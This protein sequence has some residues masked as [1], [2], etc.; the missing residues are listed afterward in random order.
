MLYHRLC[1]HYV[2]VTLGTPQ[3]LHTRVPPTFPALSHTSRRQQVD[4]YNFSYS[5]CL[6]IGKVD[7]DRTALEALCH[8][9]TPTKLLGQ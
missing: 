7:N 1:P 2:T 4:L 3:V 8:W 5:P 6:V 9:E